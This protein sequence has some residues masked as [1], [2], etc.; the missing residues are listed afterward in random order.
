MGRSFDQNKRYDIRWYLKMRSVVIVFLTCIL[1][2][3]ICYVASS[4][5]RPDIHNIS[6][7]KESRIVSI[8]LIPRHSEL[9]RRRRER[10]LLDVSRLEKEEDED[11]DEDE[12]R[13]RDEAVQ[14]GALFEVSKIRYEIVFIN[15]ILMQI[16]IL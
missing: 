10:T 13:R 14:V 4:S 15:F 12:Y 6:E 7:N 1:P 9:N 11:K 16:R 2:G 8:K 5:D 3:G